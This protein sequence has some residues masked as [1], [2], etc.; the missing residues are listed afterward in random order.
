MPLRKLIIDG[1]VW[2]WMSLHP[3]HLKK[4]LIRLIL[5]AAFILLP[6]VAMNWDLAGR[7]L[8]FR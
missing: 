6:L 5:M 7:S 3:G 2:A 8:L 1:Y 4:L